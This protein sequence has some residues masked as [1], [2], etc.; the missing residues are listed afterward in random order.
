[1][2]ASAGRAAW[3]ASGDR[4]SGAESKRWIGPPHWTLRGISWGGDSV[5]NNGSICRIH[6]AIKLKHQIFPSQHSAAPAAV[7]FFLGESSRVIL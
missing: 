4:A 1:M 5:E 7:L 2:S 3:R 6:S